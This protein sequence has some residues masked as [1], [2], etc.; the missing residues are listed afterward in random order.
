MIECK[1]MEPTKDLTENMRIL[2]DEFVPIYHEFWTA[3]G[4]EYY[5]IKDWN[6]NPVPLVQLWMER[7]L[8]L[9][10]AF[11]NNQTVGFLLGGRMTPFYQIESNC[12]I[13]AYYGKSKEIEKS[14]LDYLRSGFKFTTEKFLLLPKYKDLQ[15]SF[16]PPLTFT[17]ERQTVVYER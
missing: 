5:K 15:I 9:I 6:I 4:S 8:I 16:D 2:A 14:L 7:N 1:L 13:E 10:M 12:Y 3:R 17:G 11:E